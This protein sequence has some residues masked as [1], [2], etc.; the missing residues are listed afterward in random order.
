AIGTLI[1]AAESRRPI[2]R[3]AGSIGLTNLTP[4]TPVRCAAAHNIASQNARRCF[5]TAS[6]AAERSPSPA[7]AARL[8]TL[9][10]LLTPHD[11]EPDAADFRR[12]GGRLRGWQPAAGGVKTRWSAARHREAGRSA[13]NSA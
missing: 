12:L 13:R 11:L 9:G 4:R 3:F 1:P 5:F 7:P 6:S 2:N 8:A 10:L